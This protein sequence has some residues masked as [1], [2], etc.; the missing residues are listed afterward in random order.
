MQQLVAGVGGVMVGRQRGRA[1]RH[2]VPVER[3]RDVAQV[4][5]EF[6]AEL[7]RALRVGLAPAGPGGCGSRGPAELT[8]YAFAVA[9]ARD[10][11]VGRAATTRNETSEALMLVT[12]AMLW[13]VPG[14]PREDVLHRALRS[15]AFLGPGASEEEIPAQDRLA[16]AWVAKASRPLVDPHDPALARGVLEALRRKRDG[17]TAAPE[18]VRRKRK[19][20]VNALYYAMEQG[21]LGSHPLDRIRWRVPKQARSV[22]PRSVINP[23][24]A[25]DLLAA[26]S[27]VGGYKRAKG[28]RLV[29]LFAGM[30]YAGLRP[31]EAV[32]VTLPD[33]TL[34]ETGWG[35]LVLHRTRPQAGKK[36]TDSGQMY[37]ERGLKNRPPGEV[38]IVPLPPPLVA[39]WRDSVQMFGA[40]QDGR[41]FFTERGNIVGYTIWHRVWNGART[42]ALPPA[43][44][45]T[46]LG[47]RRYDLRHSALS[48]WLAAGADPAEVAMRA[49]NTSKSSSPA[50]PNASTTASPST[51]NASNTSSTP[52]TS[53]PCLGLRR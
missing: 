32:A 20:L 25:Q 16:L 52:T 41:L 38:R 26:V 17:G 15:W 1:F 28:R 29:G 40:A 51:T 7:A 39:I 36:W 5:G 35:R 37:D 24:Q 53:R 9:Y 45:T 18:T 4:A 12:R 43:L 14:R 44:V 8:W 46:P 33:C 34:P 47:K 21:E 31:E 11:W 30:Y 19:V 49:G 10:H 27:Y 6:G 50:T 48:T 13:D 42:L 3:G 2:D 22:D 23:H